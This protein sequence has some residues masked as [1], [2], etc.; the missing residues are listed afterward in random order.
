MQLTLGHLSL[1]SLS[2]FH[3]T[4]SPLNFELLPA[5]GLDTK[6]PIFNSGFCFCIV[7]FLLAACPQPFTLP[8]AAMN[9]ILSNGCKPRSLTCSPLEVIFPLVFVTFDSVGSFPTSLLPFWLYF[10]L[11]SYIFYFLF[12]AFPRSCPNP[13]FVLGPF[14]ISLPF[15]GNLVHSR[16]LWVTIFMQMTG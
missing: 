11:L 8:K 15:L 13:D 3:L 14:C 10:L 4:V 6:H 7:F 9:C 1:R 12:F 5:S 2:L 16:K